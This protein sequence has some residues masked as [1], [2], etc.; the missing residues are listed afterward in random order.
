MK[1]PCGHCKRDDCR[2]CYLYENNERYRA[3][4]SDKWPMVGCALKELVDWFGIKEKKG[5]GC[6]EMMSQM[7]AWGVDGCRERMPVIVAHLREKSLERGFVPLPD[8]A[9]RGLVELAIANA[10][11][12]IEQPAENDKIQEG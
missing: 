2:L 12:K 7:N 11:A 1:I 10:M 6:K 9:F 8:I 4:W 5:C 3:L